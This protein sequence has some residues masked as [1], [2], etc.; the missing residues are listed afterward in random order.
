M[1]LA[2]YRVNLSVN[3]DGIVNPFATRLLRFLDLYGGR[4]L[5]IS[6][7]RSYAEQAVLWANTPNTA[8]VA[9]P[10]TSRH[11]VG[12]AAD[13]RIVDPQV[14]WGD[15][16][17]VAAG[18]GLRFPLLNEPWHCEPDPIFVAPPEEPD[19][20]PQELAHA[21]GGALDGF[22][23]VVIPRADGNL[24]PI[25]NVLGF[26]HSEITN[27]DLFAARLKQVIES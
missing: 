8:F 15:I 10:G 7:F 5:I 22:G 18:Y 23:R 25:G 12:Q 14:S 3:T 27:N 17:T 2:D 26:I 13:L 9:R 4:V 19:M 20:T 1:G 21:L 11:E 6:G 24:Y 16:H